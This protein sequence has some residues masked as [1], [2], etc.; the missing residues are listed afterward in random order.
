MHLGLPSGY[1]AHF[2]PDVL[3]LK[4]ADGSVVAR[5]GSLGS[6]EQEVQRTAWEDHD[7]AAGDPSPSRAPS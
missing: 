4:R 2:D 7:E 1:R 6:A 3:V 5:F